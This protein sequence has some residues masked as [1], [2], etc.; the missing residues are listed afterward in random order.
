MA[1]SWAGPRWTARGRAP[2]RGAGGVAPA[3]WPPN[4]RRG[5]AGSP[6]PAGGASGASG[7]CGAHVRACLI[8]MR[9]TLAAGVLRRPSTVGTS[10]LPRC[11]RPHA[12]GCACRHAKAPAR[13]W[14]ARFAHGAM[15]LLWCHTVHPQ[16][17]VTEASASSDGEALACAPL[18]CG[19][20]LTRRT[21][22][23]H[24]IGVPCRVGECE[25]PALRLYGHG[26]VR[27]LWAITRG[28]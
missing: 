6:S 4:I 12:I 26:R 5:H 21:M 22:R 27:V 3:L 9:L 20:C 24:A 15:V 19:A 10:A 13:A 11:E 23:R 18:R 1:W 7:T 25:R 16:A 17:P 28:S 2:T 14:G 8:P